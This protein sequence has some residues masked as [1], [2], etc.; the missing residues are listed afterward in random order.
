MAA[1][2][3]YMPI[4]EYFPYREEKC[5]RKDVFSSPDFLPCLKQASE[6][7]FLTESIESHN[8][9][10]RKSFLRLSEKIPFT[11]FLPQI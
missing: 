2:P 4:T 7:S 6:I 9:K 11:F 1:Y 10:L 8:G 5:T 3:S